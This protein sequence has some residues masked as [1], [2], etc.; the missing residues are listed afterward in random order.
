M[1]TTLAEQLKNLRKSMQHNID[2]FINAKNVCDEWVQFITNNTDVIRDAMAIA[3][4]LRLNRESPIVI[5]TGHSLLSV[6][7]ENNVVTIEHSD[8]DHNRLNGFTVNIG[9]DE[10]NIVFYKPET[11]NGHNYDIDYF[12][13]NIYEF[14]G[15]YRNNSF[16]TYYRE[17]ETRNTAKKLTLIEEAEATSKLF[18]EN[19]EAII[20][21][22]YTCADKKLQHLSAENT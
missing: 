1:N 6:W 12:K 21:H 14:T 13:F 16:D 3:E 20:K 4:I 2:A 7:V 22:L 18:Y 15:L 8:E 5:S 10:T 9:K 19:F 11:K 17:W